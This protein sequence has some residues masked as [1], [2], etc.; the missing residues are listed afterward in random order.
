MHEFVFK[1]VEKY[2]ISIKFKSSKLNTSKNLR[3]I[4]NIH[5]LCAGIKNRFKN[6]LK[7][8]FLTR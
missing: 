5:V 6:I 4:K 7:M 8:K 1:T 2:F 3:K